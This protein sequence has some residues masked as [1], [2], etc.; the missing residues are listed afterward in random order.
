[1]NAV[2]KTQ[3]TGAVQEYAGGLLDVIARAATLLD[4]NPDSGVFH[5]KVTRGR[6]AKAGG[7]AGTEIQGR[8]YIK[9][10]GKMHL[11]HRLAFA[12][13]TGSFPQD[14][15]DH[16]DGDASN[17]RWANLRKCSHAEN[18]QNKRVSRSNKS[19]FLG[20]SKHKAGWQATIAV[21]K[22]Y[23]YLGL[24]KTPEAAHAAY[25]DAKSRLHQ[26]NPRPREGGATI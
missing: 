1:M 15:V 11:A 12:F 6:L 5:W 22:R 23:H 24:F 2:T 8:V 3:E 18:M 17:N 20:V 13:M 26:F 19:G 16:M 21:D 7:I 4:Y 10:D 9:I 14:R 25:L